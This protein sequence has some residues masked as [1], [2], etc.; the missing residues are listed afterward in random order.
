MSRKVISTG[1][2]QGNN[3]VNE[4]YT[5]DLYPGMRQNATFKKIDAICKKYGYDLFSAM[6]D[7]DGNFDISRLEGKDQY[8]PDINY[9]KTK[10]SKNKEFLVDIKGYGMV[11]ANELKAISKGLSDAYNCIEAIKKVDISDL[12]QSEN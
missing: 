8:H 12:Y 1:V 5:D 10:Y 11:F 6:L 9:G 7:R 4:S 3:K 2:V